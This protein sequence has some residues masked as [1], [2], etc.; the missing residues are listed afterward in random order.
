MIANSWFCQLQ[1]QLRIPGLMNPQKS[2]TEF[3]S[4][5]LGPTD[6]PTQLR[7]CRA[8][9]DGHLPVS[10][11]NHGMSFAKL[12][13]PLGWDVWPGGRAGCITSSMQGI[14]NERDGKM[15]INYRVNLGFANYSDSNLNDFTLNVIASLTGN[16]SFP[17]PPVTLA[18]LGTLQTAF[19]EAMTAAAPGGRHL[20]AAKN[21][22]RMALINALRTVATYVQGIASQDVAML[23]TSGFQANSTNRTRTPLPAPNILG[24]YNE[25]SATLT[26]RLQPVSNARA[27]QVRA[28][29]GSTVLPT[30]DSTAARRVVVGNLTPGTVYTVQCRALGGSTGYSDWSDPVSHMAL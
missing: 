4:S 26:V 9:A 7:R 21:A 15:N 25:F 8:L 3:R 14:K 12:E 29:T 6:F 18:D 27:Y 22:A 10:R 17:T 11:I 23:L 28:S 5:F 30:V 20:T 1:F 16:A 24:I 19:Q 13:S 2:S